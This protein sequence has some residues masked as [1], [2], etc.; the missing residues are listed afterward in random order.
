MFRLGSFRHIVT[1]SGHN[2]CISYDLV[3]GTNIGIIDVNVVFPCFGAT[4]STSVSGTI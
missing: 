2:C 4:G 3:I 1:T